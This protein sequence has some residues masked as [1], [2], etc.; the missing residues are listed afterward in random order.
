MT[1]KPANKKVISSLEVVTKFE[2][3]AM[4]KL[5][6]MVTHDIQYKKIGKE[7]WKEYLKTSFG[8]DEPTADFMVNKLR[9]MATRELNELVV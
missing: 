5:V 4:L 6:Q 1:S 3:M 7:E 2:L 9:K 8:W